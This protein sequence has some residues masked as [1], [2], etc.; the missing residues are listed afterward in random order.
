MLKRFI[1]HIIYHK[2]IAIIYGQLRRRKK[3]FKIMFSLLVI[4]VSTFGNPSVQGRPVLGLI[5]NYL[6]YTVPK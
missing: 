2:H 1:P 5:I 4:I 6:R 3:Y